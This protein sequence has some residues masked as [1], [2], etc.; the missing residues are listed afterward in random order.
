MANTGKVGWI[1]GPPPEKQY[2]VEPVAELTITP[3]DL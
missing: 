1:I 3:S 2:P